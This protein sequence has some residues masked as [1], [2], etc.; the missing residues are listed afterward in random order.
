MR[1][2]AAGRVRANS[3]WHIRAHTKNTETCTPISPTMIGPFSIIKD[4]STLSQN[5]RLPVSVSSTLASNSG[6]L[7]S[8]ARARSAPRGSSPGLVAVT[9]GPGGP[10]SNSWL[11]MAAPS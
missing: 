6:N 1:Y 11:P 7:A 3:P 4:G 2:F 9:A 10:K 8:A 5:G